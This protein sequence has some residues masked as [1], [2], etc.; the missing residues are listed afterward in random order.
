MYNMQCMFAIEVNVFGKLMCRQDKHIQH[1]QLSSRRIRCFSHAHI[2]SHVCL[3]LVY[4]H[5][6][7][8]VYAR[9]Q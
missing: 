4:S 8:R 1:M 2:S 7:R 6:Y 3:C 5:I 9:I